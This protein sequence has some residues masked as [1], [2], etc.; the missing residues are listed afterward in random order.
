[1]VNFGLLGIGIN[2]ALARP[3]TFV[4][5]QFGAHDV[6]IY[7]EVRKGRLVWA[8][9][10]KGEEGESDILSRT[11]RG[12]RDVKGRVSWIACKPETGA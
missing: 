8:P 6:T 2:K 3:G 5:R 11:V 9:V 1:L 12:T 4:L 10:E 7:W